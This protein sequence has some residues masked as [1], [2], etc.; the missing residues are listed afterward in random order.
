LPSGTVESVTPKE[1][2]LQAVERLT[3]AE[4][5]A[6]LRYLAG[7]VADP[8][9]DLFDQAPEDDEPTSPAEDR[10]ANEAWSEYQRGESV[11]LLE[12]R[13]DLA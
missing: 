11:S 9:A 13:R 8:V 6:A 3:D 12:A 5:E 1:K 4:A 2:L 10:S 7:V